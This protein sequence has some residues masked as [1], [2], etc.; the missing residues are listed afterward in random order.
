MSPEE[1][2]DSKRVLPQEF[3]FDEEFDDQCFEENIGQNI[4]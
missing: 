1:Y 2:Q 4:P 3:E